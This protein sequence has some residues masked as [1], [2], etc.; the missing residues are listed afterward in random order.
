MECQVCYETATEDEYKKLECSHSLC[1]LCLSK[2]RQPKCPFCRATIILPYKEQLLPVQ[3]DDEDFNLN[4]VDN[5]ELIDVNMYNFD[6][7][8][9]MNNYNPRIRHRRRRMNRRSNREITLNTDISRIPTNITEEEIS[10]ILNNDVLHGNNSEI[11]KSTSD[12]IKQE[13]RFKRNR[14]KYCNSNI[15]SKHVRR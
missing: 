1:K 6:F 13:A 5:V 11:S 9:E 7:S 14:W 8:L 2:L 15:S 3:N 4:E 10:E 12:N